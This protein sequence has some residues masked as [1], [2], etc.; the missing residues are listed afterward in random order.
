M[1]TTSPTTHHFLA[2]ITH[3]GVSRTPQRYAQ[4]LFLVDPVT[5]EAASGNATLAKNFYGYGK[6]VYAVANG[7]VA[8]VYDGVPDNPIIYIQE[9][10]S[11][12]TLAGNSV[13]IDI[14]GKKY[15]CY[16]HLI[17]G[18]IRVKK[19]DAVTEGQV[20]GLLGNSGNTDI[21]HL[22]FQVVTGTPSL[23]GAEGYPHVYRLFTVTGQVNKTRADEDVAA[24]GLSMDQL[25][26]EF[27]RYVIFSDHLPLDR[28]LME[29]WAV[30]TFP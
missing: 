18:S 13:L 17:P 25:W 3:D 27:G 5:G 14:G 28:K 26:S 24:Q 4:D 11:F 20:I 16:G 8:D 6:E 12:A 19:G 7:T 23:L 1:E 21:P 10:L 9:N 22:H 15:A 2:P 30:F 29:N